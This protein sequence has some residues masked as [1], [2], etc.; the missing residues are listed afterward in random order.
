[1]VHQAPA[2]VTCHAGGLLTQCFVVRS[3]DA[4]PDWRAMGGCA[5]RF[6]WPASVLRVG[7]SLSVPLMRLGM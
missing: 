2:R 5:I 4:R 1:M 7:G 6:L 3:S